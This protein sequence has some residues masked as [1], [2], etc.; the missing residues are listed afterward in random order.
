M[1]P[2]I[3]NLTIL[4]SLCSSWTHFVSKNSLSEIDTYA[5][6]RKPSFPDGYIT[7]DIFHL[8]CLQISVHNKQ[9]PFDHKFKIRDF[10]NF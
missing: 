1:I 10:F 9:L 8:C 4:V 2:E 7:Q 5:L 3:F 6:E